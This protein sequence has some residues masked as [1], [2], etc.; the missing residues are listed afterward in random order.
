MVLDVALLNTQ[1]Y[2][3]RIKGRVE[4][5]REWS[6]A[7]PYTSVLELLK[8]ELSGYPRLKSPTLI[9]INWIVWNRTIFFHLTVG[10]QKKK[11]TYTKLN[12]LKYNFS[13]YKNEFGFK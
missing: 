11:N 4:K 5:S 13:I 2:K 10:K 1:H 6:N 3:V 8:S 9:M 7:L 12:Y